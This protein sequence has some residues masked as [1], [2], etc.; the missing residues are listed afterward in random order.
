MYNKLSSETSPYLLQHAENPVE[1]YPWCTE[2]F[3]KARRENKPV[4]LS[5]GYSTCHWCHVMAHESFE[6][7]TVAD[8]LN[9]NYISV[10]V[11]REERP[12]ID[13]VYMRACQ[14]VT[15]SGGWPLSIFMTPD[16]R[17][18]FAGT[19]FQT[20]Q[21]LQ[22]LKLLKRNWNSHHE[23]VLESCLQIE[24]LINNIFSTQSA[25]ENS[26]G[27]KMYMVTE[28][29][30]N[31]RRD[32]DP[33]Y[34]G[35][36]NA[37]KF[38]S[39]H[40]LIFLLSNSPDMA[41]KTLTQMYKGGIFDHIGGGFS[42]YSTDEKWLVPH[43]EKMLYDNALI[44]TA[45]VMAYAKTENHLFRTIVE[46]TFDYLKKEMRSPDGGFYA[47]QDAD[48]DGVEGKYYL[49]TP[50]E[51]ISV[52][53]EKEGAEFCNQYDITEKGNYEGKSIP[54]L[55]DKNI[56]DQNTKYRA[57]KQALY[58]FR[59][60]RTALHTDHKILTGWNS[61]L[62]AAFAFAGRIFNDENYIADSKSIISF[63]EN[64]LKKENTLFSGMTDGKIKGSAFLDDYSFYIFALIQIYKSTDHA[65][66]LHTALSLS[67]KVIEDFA[68]NKMGGFFFSG[69]SNET[70]ICPVKET[71]DGAIP[72][73]NSIMMYNLLFLSS[74]E[75]ESM[76]DATTKPAKSSLIRKFLTKH[77]SFM[78]SAA[79]SYPTGHA[80]YLFSLFPAKKI[81]CRDNI[82]QQTDED[83]L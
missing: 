44:C 80:F 52:L 20:D 65:E 14:A 48:S 60:Q 19:Y 68:D 35:F 1:W 79:S 42:R 36:G 4:F 6:N 66:Y 8:Y 47:A 29:V 70:L 5:I 31:F 16:Q 49:L 43:F 13:H 17:P 57:A 67:K 28:A 73:G 33:K 3:E 53:G 62:A 27:R 78:N 63:I 82:C 11:D 24:T 64:N 9:E 22:L 39:P 50:R 46:M 37:P 40:N 26:E 76:E 7:P 30:T 81:I 25:S 21:F 71:Y 51:V 55:I 69:S 54:N 38:P 72:S 41:E 77:R 32:F 10:K 74:F 45:Y 75:V 12:D 15:G 18:F 83:I 56:S 34:G 23:L 61:L 58:E 59:K 2:A